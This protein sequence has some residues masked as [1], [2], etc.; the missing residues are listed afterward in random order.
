MTKWQLRRHCGEIKYYVALS[1]KNALR[2][3]G[4]G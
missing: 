1:Q 4:D 3:Q 2:F